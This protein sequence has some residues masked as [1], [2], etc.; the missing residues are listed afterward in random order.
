[1]GWFSRLFGTAGSSRPRIVAHLAFDGAVR[2]LEAPTSEGWRSAE[3]ERRGEDFSVKVLKYVL[4]LDPVPLALLAKVYALEGA[5]E[6]PPDPK[7]TDW[8]AAFDAL[9][10]S[11]GSLETREARQLTMTSEL[12][13][14]EAVLEGTG[15]QPAEPLRLRE[16]RAVSAREQ[17]IVTAMGAPSAFVAHA[18]EIERWFATSAFVPRAETGQ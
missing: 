15:R 5:A 1:M 12:P 18:E 17:F 13:A 8:R 9:F 2:V 3:D 6:P 16:R 7:S 4:P 11:I 14:F 10:A